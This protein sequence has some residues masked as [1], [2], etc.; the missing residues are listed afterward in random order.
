MTANK[1]SFQTRV[2]WWMV[3]CFGLKIAADLLER[4]HRF[5]EEALELVQAIGV[6]RDQCLALVDYVYGRPVG[7]PAQEVGGVMMTLSAL[8]T[9][10]DV[11]LDAAAEEELARV[12]TIIEVIRAKQAAKRKVV[13]Y[14]PG[15]EALP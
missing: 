8:C 7:K 14:F 6:T 5:L 1:P 3:D 13:G 9:A 10:A 12:Y 2:H 15:A 11:E 4:G